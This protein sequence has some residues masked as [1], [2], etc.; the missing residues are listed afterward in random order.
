MLKHIY[1]RVVT[2]RN[3]INLLQNIL[4]RKNLYRVLVFSVNALVFYVNSME[5]LRVTSLTT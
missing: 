2:F 1:I 5:I 3:I 4:E